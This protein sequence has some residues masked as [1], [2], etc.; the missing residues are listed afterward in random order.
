MLLVRIVRFPMGCS[1]CLYLFPNSQ[2]KGKR[3]EKPSLQMRFVTWTSSERS[4][5]KYRYSFPSKGN[6][7]SSQSYATG[8]LS[9]YPMCESPG[10]NLDN[11]SVYTRTSNRVTLE[12]AFNS[13]IMT[14]TYLASL[15][16]PCS[17]RMMESSMGTIPSSMP[18]KIDSVSLQGSSN[19]RNYPRLGV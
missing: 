10:K 14:S 7:D 15:A 2:A 17:K 16:L 1:A 19:R 9:G 3:S 11:Q 5:S 8:R 4:V 18:C 13:G 6:T 12:G